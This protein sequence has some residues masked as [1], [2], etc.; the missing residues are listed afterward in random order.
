MRHEHTWK[1]QEVGAYL[2]K[3]RLRFSPVWHIGTFDPAKKC[4]GSHEGNGLSVSLHPE[5]WKRITP[6]D[7]DLYRMDKPTTAFVDVLA[8]LKQRQLMSWMW[9]WA[10]DD[11]YVEQRRIYRV[12]YYDDEIADWILLAFLDEARAREEFLSVQDDLEEVR[13]R[14]LLD[15]V[16]T[17][18]MAQEV[19][20][21]E[22]PL[23][24]VRDFA[25]LC[26]V[27]HNFPRFDGLWWQDR[28]APAVYSAPRGMIFPSHLPS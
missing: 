5:A 27:A 15:Y 21:D 16:P 10:M 26:Y 1:E 6:L 19:L 18:M 13:F 28:L 4:R 7:G 25:L 20:H 3:T 9:E 11:G 8:C 17:R 2:E 23:A 14:S 12:E 24:F 22:L